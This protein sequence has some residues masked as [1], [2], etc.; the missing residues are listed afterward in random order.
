MYEYIDSFILTL[1]AGGASEKTIISYAGDLRQFADSLGEGISW[2]RV[3]KPELRRFL[4]HLNR[5]GYAKTTVSRKVSCLRS[6]F[7]HLIKCGLMESNPALSIE[8]PRKGKPLP[9][10]LYPEEILS[11]L[12]G[13]EQNPLGHRD[14][15]LLELLYATGCRTSEMVSIRLDGIDWYEYTIKV[16]GKGSK[17]RLVHFGEQA[18]KALKVYLRDARPSF[19]K[20]EEMS[21]F[22][23]Y[24]GSAL[25]QRSVGR[26]VEKHVN[27]AALNSG[28]SPHSLRHSFATHLLDNGADLRTVQELLG[29]SNLSTTQIYTHVT[30]ERLKSI[31]ALTHPRA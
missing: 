3:S 27:R 1:R 7:N 14:R 13:I 25:S 22:L 15:A 19:C 30:S 10:F 29:H 4:A 8:L 21:L 11:L 31:Y 17:E 28:I 6:F 24:R 2:E 12:Q 16:S 23:N 5:E 18:A 20:A 26:I 9:L